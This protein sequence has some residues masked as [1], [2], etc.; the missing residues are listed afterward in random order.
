MATLITGASSG[1]GEVLARRFAERGN[2]LILVARR[3]DKLQQLADDLRSRHRIEADVIA[4]DLSTATAA[5]D[6]VRRVAGRGLSVDILINNAGFGIHGPLVDA[7]PELM[8][9]QVALNCQAVV[10]L[11]TRFLPAMVER[12]RGVIINLSSVAAFQPVPKLAVYSATK[13]FVLTFTE[14]LWGEL[15]G[16]GVRALAVCPAPTDTPFFE[17]AGEAAASGKKRTTDQ[18]VDHILSQLDGNRP[19]FVDGIGYAF[20]HRVLPRFVPRRLV[21]RAAGHVVRGDDQPKSPPSQRL[22][23]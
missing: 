7:D 2:D 15:R 13:A 17:I 23:A 6:L 8:E 4:M 21:I 1:I 14:A 11:T 5:A 3:A 9:Q 19:S 20:V 22:S 12:G 10:G 16:T 18:L